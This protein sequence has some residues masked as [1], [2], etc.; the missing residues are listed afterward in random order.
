[1]RI[2]L[3]NFFYSFD[4]EETA[5]TAFL[6]ALA[7]IALGFL[8]RASNKSPVELKARYANEGQQVE[9]IYTIKATGDLAPIAA[10]VNRQEVLG[11]A[12]IPSAQNSKRAMP[13]Y[14]KKSFYEDSETG[15]LS[16][17]DLKGRVIGQLI[18]DLLPSDEINVTSLDNLAPHT[19]KNVGVV[20]LKTLMQL[21]KE[22]HAVF[23]LAAS[24]TTPTYYYK[25][26]FRVR[27]ESDLPLQAKI[28]ALA[29]LNKE[30]FPNMGFI[31][32]YLPQEGRRRWL[33]ELER[34]PIH[35]FL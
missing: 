28:A 16:A 26:G 31:S 20:L 4:K 3:F 25:L 30:L 5:Q 32:M 22:R 9:K 34:N 1:M 24:D 18:Y 2:E 10:K 29:Q 14:F 12:F 6:T 27:E 19:H 23:T 33:E 11:V 35:F 13:V 7:L 21:F 8:M 15:I 17:Y